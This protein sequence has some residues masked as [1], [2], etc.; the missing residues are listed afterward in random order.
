[1]NTALMSEPDGDGEGH[2]RRKPGWR[3]KLALTLTGASSG[4]LV[5]DL[6][7]MLG[8]RALA[9]VFA[10]AGVLAIA[11]GRADREGPGRIPAGCL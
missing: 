8:Y 7:G 3:A 9:A 5:N 2:P 10:V 6:S 1:M 4:M 11:A